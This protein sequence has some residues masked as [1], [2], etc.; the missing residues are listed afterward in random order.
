MLFYLPFVAG[1]AVLIALFVIG[2]KRIRSNFDAVVWIASGVVVALLAT[3][4]FLS[5]IPP[6]NLPLGGYIL[7]ATAISIIIVIAQVYRSLRTHHE[8]ANKHSIAKVQKLISDYNNEL[9][10]TTDIM[11]RE[12]LKH[13]IDKLKEDLS[14]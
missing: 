8:N 11:E 5:I 9:I 10:R 2:I 7:I 13:E 1:L 12:R 3:G 4:L 6:S 14:G